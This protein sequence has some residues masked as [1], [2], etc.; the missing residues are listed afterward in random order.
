MDT[1][2]ARP[3]FSVG[4][5]AIDVLVQGFPGK[6]VRHVAPRHVGEREAAISWFGDTLDETTLFGLLARK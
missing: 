4:D 3:G 5:Y 2:P 6:S 1:G